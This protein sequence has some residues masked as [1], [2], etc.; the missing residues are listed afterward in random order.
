MIDFVQTIFH[1]YYQK[2]PE[3]VQSPTSLEK[4]EFGFLLFEGQ[5]MLKPTNSESAIRA[6]HHSKCLVC[7]DMIFIQQGENLQE[8]KKV[9]FKSEVK[10]VE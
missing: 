6:I 5:A 3:C 1:E 10:V 4:H 8:S 2:T 9:A 7:G